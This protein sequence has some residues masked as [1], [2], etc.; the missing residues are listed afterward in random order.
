MNRKSATSEKP[1]RGH[2]TA[3]EAV[4]MRRNFGKHAQRTR[5]SPT[6]WRRGRDRNVFKKERPE[7]EPARY[8]GRRRARLGE[9]AP[10]EKKLY[11]STLART[12]NRQTVQIGCFP[13]S[14]AAS[15]ST[16]LGQ[17]SAQQS[18]GEGFP[19]G[20]GDWSPEPRRRGP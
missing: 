6:V 20:A 15:Y 17:G 12:Q 1:P 7:S 8:D 4:R 18:V 19:R 13:M 14:N 5:A 10:T 9:V 2:Q 11:M 3:G 16:Y